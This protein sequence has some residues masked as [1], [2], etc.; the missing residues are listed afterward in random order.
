MCQPYRQRRHSNIRGL[1]PKEKWHL[2]AID[3]ELIVLTQE[4]W[5]LQV[6]TFK[7]LPSVDTPG[8]RRDRGCASRVATPS[9]TAGAPQI[10]VH[11]PVLVP[12]V[13]TQQLILQMMIEK[14]QA[15]AAV[16]QSVENFTEE[17]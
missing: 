7:I 8:L 5:F 11:R 17:P 4:Q 10:R 9:I 13:A 6:P 15:D 14:L 16:V 12:Q 3:A 2:P 1:L